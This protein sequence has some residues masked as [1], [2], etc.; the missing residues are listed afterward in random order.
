MNCTHRLV[1]LV[2]VTGLAS[3]CAESG[4]AAP[5]VVTREAGPQAVA[6]A[7]PPSA[8]TSAAQATAPQA[9]A[10][11]AGLEINYLKFVADHH[12]MGVMMAELCVQ[13]AVHEELR[14]HCEMAAQN[15]QQE[16]ELVLN[17]LLQYYGIDYEPEM[18]GGGR[19]T[20][21]ERLSG[22]AFEIR[23]LEE[24]PRHHKSVIQRSQPLVDNAIHEEV[25]ELATSII[26]NQTQG[27]IQLVTWKC[28]WYDDCN[29]VAGFFPET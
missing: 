29:P 24:F 6:D 15:Q 5:T 25:R 27:A 28:E 2:I 1:G 7:P 19:M 18:E 3:A 4:P 16:L 12:L 23:F 20:Q 13:K 22:A 10:P 21:V 26:T 9:T 8:S 17:L 11:A 14:E